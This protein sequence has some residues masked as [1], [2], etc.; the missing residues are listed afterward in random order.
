MA[1]AGFRTLDS[2]V[3]VCFSSRILGP[4][5]TLMS[6]LLLCRCSVGIVMV[7]SSLEGWRYMHVDVGFIV[8]NAA[9]TFECTVGLG[10]GHGKVE[11]LHGYDFDW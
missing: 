11:M 4:E 1:G 7:T 6:F 9:A 2:A 5:P 10:S 3:D 8:R